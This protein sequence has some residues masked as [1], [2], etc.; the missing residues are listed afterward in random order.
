MRAGSGRDTVGVS[1]VHHCPYCE[2]IFPNLP[3]LKF[4]IEMDHPERKVPERRY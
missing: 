2:L 4:H 3:E 1:D